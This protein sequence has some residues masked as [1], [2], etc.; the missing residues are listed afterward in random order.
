MGLI[1]QEEPGVIDLTIE[2]M[3]YPISLKSENDTVTIAWR[4][5]T[6]DIIPAHD[7]DGETFLQLPLLMDLIFE[8][9]NFN[10]S[11]G[12]SAKFV[13]E[14]PALFRSETGVLVLRVMSEESF[15]NAFVCKSKDPAECLLSWIS[16]DIREWLDSAAYP[17]EGSGDFHWVSTREV[18]GFFGTDLLDGCPPIVFDSHE[19][20]LYDDQATEMLGLVKVDLPWWHSPSREEPA[21]GYPACLF[22][23]DTYECELTLEALETPS[24]A[25]SVSHRLAPDQWSRLVRGCFPGSIAEKVKSNLDDYR[26][27]FEEICN[28]ASG[29]GEVWL[30]RWRDLY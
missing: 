8:I 5:G 20:E 2:W 16:G 14:Y 17:P 7:G 30:A 10:C 11:E 27:R 9:Q 24:V 3:Q 29:L 22:L 4:D 23:P 18:L 12:Q 28:S 13:D 21:S 26:N 25:V 19:D 15:I 1:R 6:E